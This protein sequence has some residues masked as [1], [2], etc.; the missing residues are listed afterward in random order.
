MAPV[1]GEVLACL[2]GLPG[3]RIARLSGS[4][5]TCFA[6]FD[7]VMAAETAARSLRGPAPGWWTAAAGWAA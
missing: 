5:A 3:A 6:L 4:G 2:A 7:T 1:I